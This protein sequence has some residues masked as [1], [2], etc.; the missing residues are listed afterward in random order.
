MSE[1]NNIDQ[2]IA[3]AKIPTKEKIK[4][5][6]DYSHARQFVLDFKLKK[7]DNEVQASKI[8]ELYKKLKG[9]KAVSSKKFFLDFKAYIDK[10]V[11]SAGVFYL[12]NKTFLQLENEVLDVIDEKESD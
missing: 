8:Y 3:I 5:T 10:K 1:D 4:P 6:Q 12:L 7:G 11:R 9:R 2:L